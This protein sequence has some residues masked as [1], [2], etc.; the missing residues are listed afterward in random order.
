MAELPAPLQLLKLALG[1]LPGI[2]PRSAERLALHV[3][4]SDSQWVKDLAAALVTAKERI[5]FCEQCGAL[6]ETQPCDLCEDP[7][8]DKGLICVV[9]RPVDVISLEKSNAFRGIYHVL[10]GQ[11]SPLNGVGPEDLRISEL[12]ERLS[13]STIKELVLALGSDVEGDATSYYL[14]E[15]F[16]SKG[17]RITRLAHGL[18]VGGGLEFADELTIGRALEGRR[19]L[20]IE[21]SDD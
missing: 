12:E 19:N 6:T 18:P 9:E 21:E 16:Q 4:Q 11:I 17:I 15:R 2:G 20:E 7:R 3:V 10:G 14:A 8:R 5:G 1:R 13:S